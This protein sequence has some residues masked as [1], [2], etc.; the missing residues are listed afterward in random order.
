MQAPCVSITEQTQSCRNGSCSYF[1]T[2]NFIKVCLIQ[3]DFAFFPHKHHDNPVA[4]DS[5]CE[6]IRSGLNQYGGRKDSRT[7]S[8]LLLDL[9]K[10]SFRYS[11]SPAAHYS[12]YLWVVSSA[13][14]LY[15]LFA[16]IPSDAYQGCY[17]FRPSDARVEQAKHFDK[18]VSSGCAAPLTGSDVV[19]TPNVSYIS[20]PAATTLQ[21]DSTGN[22]CMVPPADRIYHAPLCCCS[23]CFTFCKVRNT[24][25]SEVRH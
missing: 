23:Y 10:L 8:V 18:I 3:S 16:R 15:S 11:F 5:S 21:M 19:T 20:N 1:D 7:E 13:H 9:E 6:I 14:S 4:L 22:I 25:R 24:S 2:L 12:F 17:N